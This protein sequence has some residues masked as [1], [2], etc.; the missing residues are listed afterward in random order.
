MA[1][2]WQRASRDVTM[3]VCS[4]V[5]FHNRTA[6][7]DS[8]QVYRRL[9]ANVRNCTDYAPVNVKFVQEIYILFFRSRHLWYAEYIISARIQ[10]V[11]QYIINE[12]EKNNQ[13]IVSRLSALYWIKG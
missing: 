8:T 9:F 1:V 12:L 7:R 5:E 6:K 10:D 11:K 2:G 3:H 4:S 13:S